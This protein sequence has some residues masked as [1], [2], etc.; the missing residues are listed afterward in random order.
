[1]DKRIIKTK[2]KIQEALIRLL[3][4]YDLIEIKVSQLCNEANVNRSTFYVHYNNVLDCFEEIE[5][6]ILVELRE[7]LFRESEKNQ[8]AFFKAYFRTARKH[9]I[10]FK[11]IHRVSIHNSLI[12]KMVHL[13]NEILHEELFIPLNGERLEFSFI[14]AG[15]Y[16]LVEAW[17]KNGCKESEEELMEILNK[18]MPINHRR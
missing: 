7:E 1:M 18:Y 16:G 9:Q 3:D 6:I 14:F 2:E 8:N 5:R 10:V 12:K 17:I 11:A 15:F 4:K 13:N